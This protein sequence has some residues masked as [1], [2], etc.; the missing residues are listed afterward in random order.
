MTKKGTSPAVYDIGDRIVIGDR[1]Y[2]VMDGGAMT[3]GE[4]VLTLE[5][6]NDE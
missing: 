4:P 6:R 5:T 3:R 1:I 2:R